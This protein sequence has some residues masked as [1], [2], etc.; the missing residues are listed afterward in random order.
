MG[1]LAMKASGFSRALWKRLGTVPVQG[2]RQRRKAVRVIFSALFP[3]DFLLSIYFSLSLFFTMNSASLDGLCATP[4]SMQ[5]GL[6]APLSFKGPKGRRSLGLQVREV[7]VQSLRPSPMC[8]SHM[9]RTSCHSSARCWTTDT[10]G[11]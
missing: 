1:A 3:F 9:A 11:Y 7:W 2:L 4:L 6:Q 5:L 8:P 10:V